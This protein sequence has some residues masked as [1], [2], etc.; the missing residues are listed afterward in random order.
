MLLFLDVDKILGTE[1]IPCC[2]CQFIHQ[3]LISRL[4]LVLDDIGVPDSEQIHLAY[5]SKVDV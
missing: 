4:P 1:F 2:C 3:L 5:V